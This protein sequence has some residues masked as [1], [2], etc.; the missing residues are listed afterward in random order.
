MKRFSCIFLLTSL[1][2]ANL[3]AASDPIGVVP[4]TAEDERVGTDVAARLLIQLQRTGRYTLVER[5]QL[6]QALAELARN[7]SGAVDAGDALQIGRMTGAQYLILGEATPVAGTATT[8][9]ATARIVRTE[10]GVVVG[11]ATATGTPA[12]LAR[13]LGRQLDDA[14]RIYLALQNPDSPYSI[15]LKL[16]R[17][18]DPTYRLGERIELKFKIER[19]RRT[20]P[21]RVYLRLYAIDARGGMRLIYP[22]KFTQSA[23]IEID[24]EYSFPD[25]R[26]GFEWA[27]VKPAGVES[28]QAVVTTSPVDFYRTK[29]RSELFPKIKAGDGRRPAAYRAIEVR[30]N[31]EKLK[32]WSAERVSYTLTE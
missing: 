12:E 18:K 21:S 23:A 15:L 6:K 2:T 13:S 32:D 7:Q 16:D 25:E 14:L 10:T 3:L 9:R 30:I 27:L 28:I 17:G 19:H 8:L 22:N 20:A 26:D 31:R 11:A 5:G 29:Y 4:F 24:K 1:F